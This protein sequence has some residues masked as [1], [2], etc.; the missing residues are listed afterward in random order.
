MERERR[1]DILRLQNET[2]E[3]RS[4]TYSSLPIGFL[5]AI[6]VLEFSFRTSGLYDTLSLDC[7]GWSLQG[8][9]PDDY[10]DEASQQMSR[11]S[12]QPVAFQRRRQQSDICASRVHVHAAF[13]SLRA[14]YI[15]ALG[16]REED[17]RR[18]LT[19]S[20]SELR[21]STI[22]RAPFGVT[23]TRILADHLTFAD[24][25]GRPMVRILE[26]EGT[27]FRH[28]HISTWRIPNVS[29]N[30]LANHKQFRLLE[31]PGNSPNHTTFF[32]TFLLLSSVN[33]NLKGLHQATCAY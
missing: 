16:L 10:D 30:S 14:D 13:G 11:G 2:C 15:T 18:A 23:F 27:Y 1:A 32:Q 31:R 26:L 4:H 9:I 29:H 28:L 19:G 17:V 25:P 7:C 8:D 33:G 22:L 6:D 3:P 24:V 5:I 21:A 20:L 12:C